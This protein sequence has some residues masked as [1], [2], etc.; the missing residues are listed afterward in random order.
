MKKESLFERMQN[1]L[2]RHSGSRRRTMFLDGT[3]VAAAL[4]GA[5]QERLPG[6]PWYE[7][8]FQRGM[9]TEQG[10]GL[11]VLAARETL[12]SHRRGAV[13]IT[14]TTHGLDDDAFAAARVAWWSWWS[15][16]VDSPELAID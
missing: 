2:E 15:Y 3:A 8:Q 10:D 12:D 14:L 9:I 16:Q 7:D 5:L 4:S 13:H 11:V 6:T 1:S